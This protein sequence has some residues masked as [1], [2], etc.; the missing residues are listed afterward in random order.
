MSVSIVLLLAFIIVL[1]VKSILIYIV[2]EKSHSQVERYFSPTSLELMLL[3]WFVYNE[4]KA[5]RR[6]LLVLHINNAIGTF[7]KDPS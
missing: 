2:D 7:N 3:V 4:V 5:W 1:I 6:Q